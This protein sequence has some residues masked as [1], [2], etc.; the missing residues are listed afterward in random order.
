M[1]GVVEVEDDFHEVPEILRLFVWVVVVV[2]DG[3]G[4]GF[5]RCGGGIDSDS[6]GG[7]TGKMWIP[8]IVS[9][10]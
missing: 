8:V 9:F 4:I 2:A 1:V 5:G 10:V 6:D 7:T 3:I